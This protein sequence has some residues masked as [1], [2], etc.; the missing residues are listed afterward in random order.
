VLVC[1]G[2]PVS[3]WRQAIP[4]P[5]PADVIV[6]SHAQP[7]R[8][9]GRTS[10]FGFFRRASDVGNEPAKATNSQGVRTPAPIVEEQQAASTS[11]MPTAPSQPAVSRAQALQ[12]IGG[13]LT[14]TATT[15]GDQPDAAD[16]CCGQ[17]LDHRALTLVASE[18]CDDGLTAGC[19]GCN[20]GERLGVAAARGATA[21]QRLTGAEKYQV[22]SEILPIRLN[23]SGCMQHGH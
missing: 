8:Q 5:R 14:S 9:G 7:N 21:I 4:A 10:V 2:L 23:L 3:A 1:Q 20:A 12:R 19:D 13:W 15:A 16:R 6:C 18:H 17:L 22:C 11:G